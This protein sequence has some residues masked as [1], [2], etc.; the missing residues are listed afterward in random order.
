MAGRIPMTMNHHY[1][2]YSDY[3]ITLHM[4]M[5]NNLVVRMMMATQLPAFNREFCAHIR[6]LE[7]VR[8]DL[9]RGPAQIFHLSDYRGR[10]V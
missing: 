5:L 7:K 6:Q 1:W 8:D 2:A 9:L 3:W 4:V 10:A